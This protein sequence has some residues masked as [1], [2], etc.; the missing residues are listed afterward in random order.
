LPTILPVTDFGG[1]R[2]GQELEAVELVG[3]VAE[4]LPDGL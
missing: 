4:T 3:V 1:L 2:H